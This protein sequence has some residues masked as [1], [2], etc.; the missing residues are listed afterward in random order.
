MGLKTFDPERPYG[1]IYGDPS[2]GR[3]MQDGITFG[4]DGL[5]LNTEPATTEDVIDSPT[6]P[7][8]ATT[9]DVIDSPPPERRKKS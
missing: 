6:N 3:Y 5:P 2:E 9:E 7:E 1:L 4:A 8:P